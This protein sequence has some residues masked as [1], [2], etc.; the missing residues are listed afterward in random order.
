MSVFGRGKQQ[1]EQAQQVATPVEDVVRTGGK[2]RP[3]PKRREAE[4]LRRNPVVKTSAQQ[5]LARNASKEE[6]KAARAKDREARRRESLLRRQALATGDERYLP[7]RDKGPVR[8]W[9]RDWV[10]AR[11]SV[12][13]FFIPAA[14]VVVMLGLFQPLAIYSV[15]GLYA[16]VLLVVVDSVLLR[17]TLKRRLTEKFGADKAAGA[18]TYGMMRALQ[19]RRTR[20]PRPQVKR[21]QY[22]T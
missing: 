6:K 21:G 9:T 7:E 18:P 1:Q 22:P 13:E 19:I 8:R 10:D 4:M 15:I 5:Q 3:T 17:R 16:I 12:G 20:L 11:W 2:G 14:L